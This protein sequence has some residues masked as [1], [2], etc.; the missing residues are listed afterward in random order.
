MSQPLPVEFDPQR[1]ANAGEEFIARLPLAQFKRLVAELR[2]S[3]GEVSAR[4]RLS[5]DEAG[6]V[7]VRGRVQADLTLRCE[8][9]LGDFVLPVDS[10]LDLLV[11]DSESAAEALPDEI[12]ALI[13]NEHGRLRAV[14]LLEDELLLS[15][16]IVAKHADEH[17]C[18][19]NF[20]YKAQPTA[21]APQAPRENPFAALAGLKKND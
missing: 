15:L 4:L 7:L 12:E 20:V 3:A 13:A 2:D 1:L 11:V 9:C 17:D 21:P 18:A 16:P 6:R 19:G 14:D 5:C 10:D 8:R